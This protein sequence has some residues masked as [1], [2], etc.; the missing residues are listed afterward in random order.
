MSPSISSSSDG[1][2]E[3]G[4]EST[5]CPCTGFHTSSWEG[6]VLEKTSCR[7]WHRLSQDSAL[8]LEPLDKTRFSKQEMPDL[9]NCSLSCWMHHCSW[10]NR[11]L[12]RR[13]DTTAK[14]WENTSVR[15]YKAWLHVVF[16]H[17]D[18]IASL[19]GKQKYVNPANSINFTC[20]ENHCHLHCP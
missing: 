11:S 5:L 3:G 18:F 15:A 7:H 4:R 16:S 14:Y 13:G 2:T 1:S 19:N 17:S 12:S 20:P 10:A 8:N 9:A 6:V